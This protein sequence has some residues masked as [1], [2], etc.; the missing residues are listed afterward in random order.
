MLILIPKNSKVP[1][2]D[3]ILPQFIKKIHDIMEKA[4]NRQTT[5]KTVFKTPNTEHE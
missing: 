5:K 4:Y 1:T 2:R 3:P